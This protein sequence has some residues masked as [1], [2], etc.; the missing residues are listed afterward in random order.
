MGWSKLFSFNRSISCRAVLFTLI[1]L[2]SKAQFQSFHWLWSTKHCIYLSWHGISVTSG[3]WHVTYHLFKCTALRLV[4]SNAPSKS[5]RKLSGSC[6]ED[7]LSV[8]ENPAVLA[9][10]GTRFAL[11]ISSHGWNF[12]WWT[13][14]PPSIK[15]QK[16][17]NN[18]MR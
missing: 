7:D 9:F 6:T 12:L 8:I 2:L 16:T 17:K 10:I 4:N 5:S 14:T 18:R 1:F 13:S 3:C 11:L 15:K